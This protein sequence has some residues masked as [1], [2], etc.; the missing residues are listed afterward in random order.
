MPS[1]PLWKQISALSSADLLGFGLGLEQKTWGE[2]KRIKGHWCQQEDGEKMLHFLMLNH[3]PVI[4]H[5]KTWRV[6]LD[7][8][9]EIYGSN[10]LCQLRGLSFL[11][12]FLLTPNGPKETALFHGIIG[13]MIDLCLWVMTHLVFGRR[14]SL[15]NHLNQEEFWCPKFWE[16]WSYFNALS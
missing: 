13:N 8:H 9:Y 11:Y 14:D 16:I 3:W 10:H 4:F 5:S 2:T 12:I 15:E 1:V 7:L 6:A